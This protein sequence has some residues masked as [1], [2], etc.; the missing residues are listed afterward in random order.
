MF[1][2][3]VVQ[4]KLYD[5]RLTQKGAVQSYEGH[6]NSH[7]RI[8]V[9]VD[10]HER[11]VMSG[12]CHRNYQSCSIKTVEFSCIEFLCICRRWIGLLF[13]DLEH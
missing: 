11:F 12:V 4:I 1:Y 9:G 3:M 7:K 8:E 2:C 5:H 6:V 10:P 13:Q